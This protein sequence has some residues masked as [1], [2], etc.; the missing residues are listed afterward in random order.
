MEQMI[1][2]ARV[3]GT[4]MQGMVEGRGGDFYD[5]GEGTK[6]GAKK[7]NKTKKAGWLPFLAD[8]RE[9]HPELKGKDVMKAAAV[10][11]NAFKKE[12]GL[13]VIKKK[14]SKKAVAKK[15][16]KKA[17]SK[18]APKK[19]AVKKA[20]KKVVKKKAPKSGSKRV[21]GYASAAEKRKVIKQ[22]KKDQKKQLAMANK[23]PI[24]K[25]EAKKKQKK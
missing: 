9:R 22:L 23:I 24:V 4:P 25:K 6:K 12:L 19:A 21:A 11:Y 18:K 13:D 8:Y 5:G 20:D 7:A 14:A 10:E 1:L 17:G 2:N 3:M 15:A 16:P